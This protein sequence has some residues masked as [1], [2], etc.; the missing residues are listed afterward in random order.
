MADVDERT[1]L[2]EHD[3]SK[4]ELLYDRFNAA[5]K[6]LIIAIVSWGGL[7]PF[8]TSGTFIPSIP[9][10]AKELNTTGNAV[11]IAVSIY[12]LA[13]ALGSL[14]GSA[15]A[16]FY[17]RR[18]TYL[19]S[20]PVMILGSL[21]VAKAQTIQQLL[22]FRFIQALGASPGTSVGFGVMGDIYRLEERG[23]A[24]G[25]YYG[26]T[27]IG[28]ALAPTVGGFFAYHFSWRI[29]HLS[30]AAFALAA[31]ICIFFYFPETIHPGTRGSDQYRGV[32]PSWRPVIL[33]P[34]AQLSMLRSPPILAVSLGSL[35]TLQCDFVMLVPLAYTI[36]KRYGIVNEA[37][38]GLCF[39][40]CGIG[41][42]IGAP[43]SGWISDVVIIR[44]MRKR[45][46]IWYPEDRLRATLGGIFLP[47][48]VIL[49]GIITRYVPGVPGLAANLVCLFMTGVAVDL[50]L[51]PCGA[52]VVDILNSRSAES[53]AVIN[54]FRYIALSVVTS[55]ILPM[56]HTYGH[57]T[58]NIISAGLA[59]LGFLILWMTIL[60]GDSMRACVDIGYTT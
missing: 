15:Y 7:V 53:A 44:W 9:Q 36:G 50:V 60:F 46:G 29:L 56:I 19:Y 5:E 17:G 41:N 18:P 28:L 27:L 38:I 11:S 49:S 8:L 25:S 12:I 39:L 31:F 42:A 35:L 33:N 2:L 4:A 57:L 13:A 52:Y 32:H 1:P 45:G 14:I 34:F 30:L 55:V 3:A 16:T 10:I 48:A 58:T 20:L 54:A 47:V 59:C 40:P 24:M 37:I 26:A 22:V 21:G 23:R 6:R 43:L 51:T